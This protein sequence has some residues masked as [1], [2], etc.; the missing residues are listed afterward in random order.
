MSRSGII[1]FNYFGGKSTWVDELEYYFPNHV[2]FVDVFCGSM[3]VTLN[4]IPSKLDT[5]NDLDSSIYNFFKV[6]REYPE[7]LIR[8]LMLTAV[9]REE[10]EKAFPIQGE[11]ISN[12][13]HARRFFVRCRMSFQGTGL[14]KSTGF[15]AC[16]NT[17]EKS[18]SKNVNKYFSAIE[19]LPE[20]VSRIQDVQIE[21]MDYKQLI[22]K[23]DRPGTFFYCD[24]PYELRMRKY[25]KW[26]N[27]EFEDKDHKKMVEILNNVEGKVMISGYESD[28]YKKLLSGW[29]F[30]KLQQRGHSRK[31]EK[32][33][34]CIWMNYDPDNEKGQLK[35]I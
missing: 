8:Q 34:E 26:Y 24:P 4:K 22:E 20:I 23:Y 10:Y 25:K 18:K 27:H 14:K 32:I 1:P 29:Y 17:S 21:C 12:I 30:V 15:N 33:Q 7:E 5:A 9:S 31:K 2:H 28:M 6:L 19:K 16:I 11:N 3:A 35:L 13:E